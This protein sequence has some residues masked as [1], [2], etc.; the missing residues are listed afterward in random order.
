ML[1]RSVS[2][3]GLAATMLA[4]MIGSAP[5]VSGESVAEPDRAP[6]QADVSAPGSIGTTPTFGDLV[7]LMLASNV[8]NDIMSWAE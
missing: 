3:S 4:G 8:Y 2:F 6:V 7:A 5:I 1:F